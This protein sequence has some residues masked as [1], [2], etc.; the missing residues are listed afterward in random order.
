MTQRT[1][2]CSSHKTG[3]RLPSSN[4]S[5]LPLGFSISEHRS[6]NKIWNPNIENYRKLTKKNVLY[7]DLIISYFKSTQYYFKTIVKLH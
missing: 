5:F 4:K 3:L 1:K 7:K 2:S 6:L